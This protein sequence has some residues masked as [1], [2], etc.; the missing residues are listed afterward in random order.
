MIHLFKILLKSIIIAILLMIAICFESMLIRMGIVIFIYSFSFFILLKKECDVM[1]Y[2]KGLEVEWYLPNEKRKFAES[3]IATS[4]LITVLSEEYL[5]ALDVY[6]AI[7]YDDEAKGIVKHFIENGYGNF[8]LR[9]FVHINPSLIY[10]KLE[11]DE[12]ISVPQKD[13]KKHLDFINLDESKTSILKK[14]PKDY[15]YD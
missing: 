8:L 13:L 3:T 7:N 14:F 11:N 15:D 12:I 1:G 6:H 2:K 9:D 10:K 5:T 4:D